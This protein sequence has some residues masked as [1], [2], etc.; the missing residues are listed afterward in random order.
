VK[1]DDV[2][3]EKRHASTEKHKS[4]KDAEK[5]EKR[6]NLERQALEERQSKQRHKG[7]PEEES[8]DEDDGDDDDDDDDDSEGKVAR[9]DWV[10]QSLL[11]TNVS[12][13]CVRASEGPQGGDLDRRQK[14]A[15]PRRP[16]ADTPPAPAQG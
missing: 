8:P 15:S 2:E 10:L 3:H 13:S 5:K 7:E 9:L 12:S 1:E 14:E 11:Q 16:L 4:A 6:K